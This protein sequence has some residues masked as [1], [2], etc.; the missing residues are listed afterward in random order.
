ME[1]SVNT[2]DM[3]YTSWKEGH[4]SIL[5][6]LA[7]KKNLIF[8]SGG[9][10][11]SVALD[12]IS[13]AC[14]EF[15]FDYEVHAG[16]FPIHRYSKSEKDK[17]SS[18]WSNHG[19][20]IKWHEFDETDEQ[21]RNTENPCHSCQSIRKKLLNTIVSGRTDDL[22]KLVLIISFS[23]WDLVGYSL[24]RI[25]GDIYPGSGNGK[26]GVISKRFLETAQRFYPLLNMKEGYTVFRP[27]IKYNG[28]DI[29]KYIEQNEIPKLSI[30]CEFKEFRPKRVLEN[31]YE[32]MGLKF[33]YDSV[34]EFAKSSLDLPDMAFYSTI[35]KD[36]YLDEYF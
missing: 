5:G 8:Y 30:P 6:S 14:S 32:K 31:Y 9:K 18:Y 10:D 13:K 19:V 33:D 34:L 21:I 28:S 36:K 7:G 24:E 20:D 23:L 4:S 15:K 16:A 26:E 25:L 27:L 29:S 22:N 1:D 2:S 12:F 17:L 11:S 35:G 3:F